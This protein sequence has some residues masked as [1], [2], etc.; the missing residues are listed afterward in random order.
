MGRSQ[1]PAAE[2]IGSDRGSKRWELGSHRQVREARLRERLLDPSE[3]Q[4]VGLDRETEVLE[5][6]TKTL[7]WPPE[8]SDRPSEALDWPPE[9]LDRPSEALDWPSEALDWPPEALDWPPKALD[10]PTKALAWKTEASDWKT[11]ASEWKIEALERTPEAVEWQSKASDRESETSEWHSKTLARCPR[12]LGRGGEFL[13][14]RA[15]PMRQRLGLRRPPAALAGG[16]RKA[17]DRVAEGT[18]PE[19]VGRASSRAF[20]TPGPGSRVRSPHQF[21]AGEGVCFRSIGQTAAQSGGGPP[22]S[23]TLARGTRRSAWPKDRS[24]ELYSAVARICNPQ[25]VG[26]GHRLRI[27][28]PRYSRLKTCAT[29]GG[30]TGPH[31]KTLARG[32]KGRGGSSVT[33]E[34]VI[35][36]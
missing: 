31:S 14:S 10:W 7:D 32:R 3:R 20:P 35:E 1:G 6:Q 34:S 15:S 9:A 4:P 12:R 22:H 33:A 26:T 27:E 8:A 23:K 29:P 17:T 13:V 25:G 5:C 18:V 2:N 19:R 11:E 28:N 16:R 21:G 30:Q 36:S 24:A